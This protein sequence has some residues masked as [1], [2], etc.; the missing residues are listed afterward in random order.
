MSHLFPVRAK[1]YVTSKTTQCGNYNTIAGWSVKLSPIYQSPSP[2]DSD[3]SNACEENR[4]FG[5]NT[6]SGD[7]S[8]FITNPIAAERFEV[9]REY[10]VDFTAA[11]PDK[12]VKLPE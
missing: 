1:F 2:T 12:E 9:G 3:R 7:I 8:M 4:I 10:Y 6:P 5:K 11:H